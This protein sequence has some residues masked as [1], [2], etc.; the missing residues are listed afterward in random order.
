MDIELEESVFDSH[1]MQ[2]VNKRFDRIKA[3]MTLRLIMDVGGHGLTAFMDTGP[4]DITAVNPS[5]GIQRLRSLG[6]SKPGFDMIR[7]DDFTFR[8]LI[9]V[10]KSRVIFSLPNESKYVAV[11]LNTG[12]TNV[13][14]DCSIE[15]L[16]ISLGLTF[17][18]FN[19]GGINF[20]RNDDLRPLYF[21]KTHG[22][23]YCKAHIHRI[24]YGSVESEK[25]VNTNEGAKLAGMEGEVIFRH[26]FTKAIIYQGY[27]YFILLCDIPAKSY[28]LFQ[29][30]DQTSK[31]E[32]VAVRHMALPH[33]SREYPTILTAL[34]HNLLAIYNIQSV[35]TLM[36]LINFKTLKIMDS[37]DYGQRTKNYMSLDPALF[38]IGKIEYIFYNILKGA[39]NEVELVAVVRHSFHR[40]VIKLNSNAELHLKSLYNPSTIFGGKG[41][42][43]LISDKRFTNVRSKEV[44]IL[45]FG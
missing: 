10:S 24:K 30:K 45:K 8:Q 35:Y 25:I 21:T 11:D 39:K 9:K 42:A 4:R 44:L 28:I 15:Q 3:N 20:F 34:K 43:F 6:T 33:S 40:L 31:S 1:C 27:L 29:I 12:D 14:I 2:K 19:F 13:L 7:R 32:V 37:Y 5:G 38:V 23:F 41:V 26:Y 16:R 18:G 17:P 22:Y 36:E